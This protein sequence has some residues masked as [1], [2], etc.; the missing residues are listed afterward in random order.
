MIG[1]RTITLLFY[2]CKAITS[3]H[4]TLGISLFLTSQEPLKMETPQALWKA[5]GQV[6]HSLCS[7]RGLLLLWRKMIQVLCQD[8]G[9]AV[10]GPFSVLPSHPLLG[11]VSSSTQSSQ[12]KDQ[13]SFSVPNHWPCQ[14]PRGLWFHPS[15]SNEWQHQRAVPGT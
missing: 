5:C 3:E 13:E 1:N 12:I 4:E 9:R 10:R 7:S 11:H 14:G 8:V 6:N 2:G 15:P